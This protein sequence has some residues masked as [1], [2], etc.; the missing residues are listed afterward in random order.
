MIKNSSLI[1][2]LFNTSCIDRVVNIVSKYSVKLSLE[3]FNIFIRNPFF[4]SA[5]LFNYRFLFFFYRPANMMGE[6]PYITD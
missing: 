5:N 6:V 4:I 1:Y 3:F 2:K